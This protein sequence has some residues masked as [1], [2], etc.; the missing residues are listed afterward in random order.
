MRPAQAGT[1]K[2]EGALWPRHGK[3]PLKPQG[4]R[5][6]KAEPEELPLSG[7]LLENSQFDSGED[8]ANTTARPGSRRAKWS[9]GRP[10]GGGQGPRVGAWGPTCPAGTSLCPSS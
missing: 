3:Q 10:R 1:E 2:D 8:K 6:T 9:G 7:K 4:F 5:S